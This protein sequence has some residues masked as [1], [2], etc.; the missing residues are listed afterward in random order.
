LTPP[1]GERKMSVM[2]SNRDQFLREVLD[3][4]P[5]GRLNAVVLQMMRQRDIPFPGAD[6]KVLTIADFKDRIASFVGG[7]DVRGLQ[8][9]RRELEKSATRPLGAA[10]SAR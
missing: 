2:S 1:P 9:L 10:R 5:E 6:G 4:V 8:Q 7:L 3:T